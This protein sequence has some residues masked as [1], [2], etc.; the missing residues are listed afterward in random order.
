[1]ERN[2]RKIPDKEAQQRNKWVEDNAM[3]NPIVLN[4]APTKETLKANRWGIHGNDIYLRAADGT[5]TKLTGT[6]ID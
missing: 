6:N 4:E 3:G 5:L 1:M 2:P